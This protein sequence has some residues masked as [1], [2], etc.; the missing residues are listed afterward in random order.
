MK[1]HLNTL[2]ITTDHSWLSLDGE[3]VAVSVHGNLLGRIPLHNLQAIQTFGWSIVATPQLM[4]YCSQKGVHLFFCSPHGKLLCNVTSVSKGNVLL[5]RE[6]YRIADVETKSLCIAREMVAAKILN[7][8]TICQRFVRDHAS[9]DVT[10]LEILIKELVVCV[11]RARRVTNF[12]EL[13]GIEGNA[14][15]KY[16]NVFSRLICIDGFR[17]DGRNRRPP[18]DEVN[19]LLSFCYSLL[20]NDCKSALESVG[21]D[22]F[23]GFYHKERPGRPSL[24]LDLMEEFR[25]PLVDKFILSLLNKRQVQPRNFRFESSGACVLSDDARKEI[26]KQWQLRKDD[27]I[28][29]PYLKEKITI[30]ILPFIQARLLAQFIRGSLNVYIPMLWK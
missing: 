5:R 7:T 20:A 1:K 18:K 26:L 28:I 25:A 2:Y 19:A 10:D 17:F 13:L 6:Q 24:A 8:R 3:T 27:K 15:E 23:V 4:A 16:F 30:G 12:S 29:H 21:L 22:S 11:K 14:A 9:L